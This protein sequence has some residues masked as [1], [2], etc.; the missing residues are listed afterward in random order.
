MASSCPAVKIGRFR[1]ASSHVSPR[2]DNIH[3]RLRRALIVGG[4]LV[5]V[6]SVGAL[7]FGE[8][9]I[10]AEDAAYRAPSA[11]QCVPSQLNRSAVLPGTSVAVTPLPDSYDASAHT[12]I[13][14][15]GAP[16]SAL[17]A[18]RRERVKQRL[19]LRTPARLL[20][21]R[22]R[23]LRPLASLRSRRDRD[24]ARAGAGELRAHD[25]V[26]LPLR[27]RSPG[28]AARTRHWPNRRRTTPRSSTFTPHRR[29]N[30][31]C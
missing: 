23:E 21:G 24:R 13:S 31:R 20:A 9:R 1:P 2:P 4:M 22:R 29:C 15:L 19:A 10:V 18:R 14:L 30:R 16:A 8:R 12:Q 11:P 5:A 6:S 26:R 27:H 25:R 3:R 7:A 17:S 28:H